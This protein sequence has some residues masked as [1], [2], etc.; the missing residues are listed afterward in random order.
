M[1]IQVPFPEILN[2]GCSELILPNA[3][4]S[5]LPGDPSLTKARVFMVLRQSLTFILLLASVPTAAQQAAPSSVLEF[6]G[7]AIIWPRFCFAPL[8]ALRGADAGDLLCEHSA[9]QRSGHKEQDKSTAT[10]Q[11][12][13]QQAKQPAEQSSEQS[14]DQRRVIDLPKGKDQTSFLGRIF[15]APFRAVA[16]KAD[17]GLTTF[18]ERRLLD[19]IKAIFDNPHY[20]PLFGGLGDGSGFGGGVELATDRSDANFRLLTSLHVTLHKYLITTFGFTADPTGS[21]R[22][23]YQVDVIGR[24]QVRPQ[25][26][27]Y[28]IGPDS[29]LSNRTTYNL[30]ERGATATASLRPVKPLRVGFGVDFSS[31]RVFGGTD[32]RFRETQQV[33]PDL[34]GFSRGAEMIG[35]LAFVELDTRDQPNRPRKGTFTSLTATSYDALGGGDFGFLNY[36]LDARGYVPLGTARRVLALR[37]LGLFND[38]KG[39]SEIPFFRLAR[40]GDAR[41]LRGYDSFRF[42][43]RNALAANVEYRFDLIPGIGALLFTDFGQVFNRRSELNSANLHA[44]YGGGVEF[45]SKRS[46]VFRVLVAKSPEGMRLM[47]GFGPTF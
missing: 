27:F 20:R 37:L 7:R 9:A 15:Q 18:E 10:G 46:T 13:E 22:E 30:Q 8:L 4:S 31:N 5:A 26:D 21:K 25:E 28:G 12:P 34:P 3:R 42:Y 14:P 6:Q 45:S 39:G 17:R 44:T 38:P 11:G 32:D 33:F 19:R 41:T 24:Y 1:L 29:F 43:G 23:R 40:I 2:E 16:P 35:P 36:R 47:L